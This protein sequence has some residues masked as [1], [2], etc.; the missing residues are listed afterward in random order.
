MNEETLDKIRKRMSRKLNKKIKP[1]QETD[2]E[3]KYNEL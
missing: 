3:Q 2:C 1:A